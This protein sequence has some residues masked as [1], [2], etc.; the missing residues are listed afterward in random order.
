MRQIKHSDTHTHT[1]TY[2][3]GRLWT[4][5]QPVAETST[6]K[7]IILTRD[8]H[9]PRGIRTH[10]TSK[11]AAADPRR[12]LEKSQDIFRTAVS[13]LTVAIQL[14]CAFRRYVCRPCAPLRT[15][16]LIFV[17]VFGH[18]AGLLGWGSVHRDSFS[19]TKQGHARGFRLPPR[20][21]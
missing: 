16:F 6:S 7:P 4:S 15:G 13:I 14:V 5:D 1:H 11:R 20:C 18:L 9:S 19:C 10:N 3:V 12:R 17:S 8:V 2:T 21:K